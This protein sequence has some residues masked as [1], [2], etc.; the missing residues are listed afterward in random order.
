MIF[1]TSD[2]HL[3]HNK[4]F[5]YGSRGFGSIEDMNSAVVERWNSK[6]SE[7]DDVYILG[8]LMLCDNDTAM[9]LVRQLNGKIHIILGNHDTDNRV[10]LYRTLANVVEIAYATMVKY[11]GLKFFMTHYPCVTYNVPKEGLKQMI[12]S[13]FGHTHEKEKFYEDRFYMYNVALDAHDLSPVSMDEVVADIR[14]KY[15]EYVAQRG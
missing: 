11:D 5:L 6:V 14:E 9:D 8:D 13:L 15:N 1:V 3:C 10:V 12:I 7:D 4:E 2:L